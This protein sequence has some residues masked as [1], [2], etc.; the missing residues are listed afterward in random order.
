MFV[1][2]YLAGPLFHRQMKL[3]QH[4]NSQYGQSR[5]GFT[6]SIGQFYSAYGAVIGL[7]LLTFVFAIAV[8]IALAFVLRDGSGGP[9]PRM[10]ALI[11]GG[12][13]VTLIVGMLL[14]VPLWEAR[15]QNLIWNHTQ[16]GPHRFESTL[17]ARHL[18]TIQLGNLLLILLTF[19]LYIP[20]AAV[21]LARYRASAMHML[22]A[23]SL[24][25][26][27]AAQDAETSATGEEATDFFDIDIGL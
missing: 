11:T 8:P 17:K 9:D 26:F 23:G 1:T 27:A 25:D 16:L 22:V 7:S 15:T 12:T 21:R 24:E 14:I 10:I 18:L 4:G 2:A 13:V 3:Y 20:W 19:G 5:F 6:A